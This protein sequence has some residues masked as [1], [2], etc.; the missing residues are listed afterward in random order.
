MLDLIKVAIR[1]VGRNTRRALITMITVFIGVFVVVGIRGLL[2][3]LQD[4]IKGGLTRKMHGDIQVH[5]LG[6]EDTLEANPY[7]IL[8]TFSETI[9]QSIRNTE[10]VAEF[11]PRLKVMALLNH[12]KSQSTTPVIINGFSSKTELAVVPRFQDSL[13]KGKM[14]DSELEK[15]AKTVQDNDLNEA[16]G[17]DENPEPMPKALPKA[18]GYHQLMVTPSL[19]RGLNAE[20]GDEVVVLLQDKDN[21]QQAVVATLVGVIDFAMPGAQARMAWMDFSTLQATAGVMGQASE[22]AIRIHEKAEDEVVKEELTKKLDANLTVQTWVELAGF[23]RDSLILQNVIFNLVLF[24]VFS[25]MISA[26]VNTSLMT[27]MER[28]R[29]IGTLMALGYRRIHITLQF[30]IESVVIGLIGGLAGMILAVSI[31]LYLHAKGLAFALP[32]QTIATVLYPSVSIG[33]LIK[34]FFLALASALVAS[35]IPAYR[36]SKMKPVQALTSN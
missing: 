12:Q 2:N 33:F 25:I 11:T 35:F 4:E 22:I 13:Q 26:I 14:I 15:A 29:E 32:G 1:N 34:V 10:G 24:I 16:K 9:I 19:M 23:L 17:L 3:G 8:L 36:A 5:R 27:V 20:I 21:M 30:L 28:T 6:Y 18:V 31:L 7:K